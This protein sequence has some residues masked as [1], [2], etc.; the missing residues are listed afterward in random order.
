MI[1]PYFSDLI[2]TRQRKSLRGTGRMEEIFNSE[3]YTL[4]QNMVKNY[5][6][7]SQ[8]SNKL[9]V[10]ILLQGNTF[11]INWVENNGINNK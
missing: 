9:K 6:E 5:Q 7:G 11:H 8:R 3:K 2:C 10:I 4:P 1:F